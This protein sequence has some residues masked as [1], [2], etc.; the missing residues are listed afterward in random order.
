MRTI[1]THISV[2]A[3][4]VAAASVSETFQKYLHASDSERSNTTWK[5]HIDL[6]VTLD[7][8]LISA[9]PTDR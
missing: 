5:G 1:A 2:A 3:A 8:D 7:R 4:E 9:R 6:L